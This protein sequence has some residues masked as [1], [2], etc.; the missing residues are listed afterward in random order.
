MNTGGSKVKVWVRIRPSS[1]FAHDAIELLNDDKTINIHHKR[2]DKKCVVNNQKMDWSFQLDGVMHDISQEDVHNRVAADIAHSA[3]N[4]YNGT[5]MCYGQTGAGKTY[6]MTGA[7]ENYKDR[8]IIPRAITQLFREIDEMP[9]KV[10]SVRISYLEIYNETMF[11]L[12]ST[13]PES[14]AVM[15]QVTPLTVHED[16]E[17]GVYVK[18]LSCHLA[19]NEEEAL[20]L[21]FEG[22]TN[23]AIAAHT[24]NKMSSRSHCIFTIYMETHS[25]LQSN[26]KYLLSKLN[27]VDLAGSE[28]L[29][30]TNSAGKTLTEA[31][32]INKSLSFLEQTVIALADRHRDHVPFRHSKL[33]HCLKNSIGGSSNTLLIANVRAEMLHMEET[34]STLRFA[35]RMMCVEVKP[36]VNQKYDP[37]RLV[38]QLQHEIEEL[39]NEL[40]MHDTLANRSHMSYEPLSEQQLYEVKQQVIQFVEGRLDEVDIVNV[41]QIQAVYEGFRELCRDMGK[42][43]ETRLR[44]RY[45][46]ID[47]TDPASIVAAQQA[48]IPVN[49]DGE[50]VGESDG[51]GFGIGPAVNTTKPVTSSIISIKKRETKTKLKGGKDRSSPSLK[52]GSPSQSLKGGAPHETLS[53]TPSGAG[54]K[55]DKRDEAGTPTSL[56][57]DGRRGLPRPST[58]PGRMEA[59]DEFKKEA[60]SEIN[61]ILVEN[62][63]ILSAKKK[64]YADLARQINLTKMEIDKCRVRLEEMQREREQQYETTTEGGEVIIGEDEYLLIKRLREH[65][66]AYQMDFEELKTLKS[67][68]KYCEKLVEQSRHRLVQEFDNWYNESFILPPPEGNDMTSSEAGIGVRAGVLPPQKSGLVIEDEQEKFERLQKSLLLENPES[69]AFY[70]AKLRIQRRKNYETAMSQPGLKGSVTPRVISRS[71]HSPRTPGTPKKRIRNPPPTMLQTQY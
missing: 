11:D 22:E 39:R 32:Y 60:G 51:S 30:K 20:N 65:K 14:M 10:V 3:L 62:K 47:R 8:G 33:T 9:G 45:T 19:Q 61:R 57:P 1:N 25:R 26:A 27:F 13:L 2:P 56:G 50:L 59:F 69:A 24:L 53:Q 42:D 6:T 43:I 48:G 23:R 7:T 37:N 70:N 68:V 34:V 66:M 16:P 31:M 4:G 35:M 58:P 21:L 18:G 67:E 55:D 64:A 44:S 36:A 52:S 15:D 17:Y 46:F 71:P 38:T 54:D 29:K 40:A 63:E 12:L 28:R 41:R 49:D 5:L